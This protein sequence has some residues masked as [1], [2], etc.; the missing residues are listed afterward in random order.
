MKNW[1]INISSNTSLA[2]LGVVTFTFLG[3]TSCK[4]NDEQ[5]DRSKLHFIEF[6]RGIFG[7]TKQVK[8]STIN[9]CLE[10]ASPS[11]E[12]EWTQK[13][14]KA[15]LTWIEPIR[16]L[17]KSTLTEKVEVVPNSSNCDATVKIFPSVHAVTYTGSKPT[18]HMAASGYFSNYNV[19]LHE[20]GHVFGLADTYQNG[21][22]GNCQPGQPQAIMCNTAFKDMQADDIAG[23]S[24]VYKRA[25]PND[26]GG[27]D[28]GPV[29]PKTLKG[30]MRLAVSEKGDRDTF[31][32]LFSFESGADMTGNLAIEFCEGSKISCA[33]NA[34][35]W[36]LTTQRDDSDTVRVYASNANIKMTEGK[37]IT[38]RVK[39]SSGTL[40]RSFKINQIKS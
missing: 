36:I 9:V 20:F 22:S 7:L 29:N 38:V 23:V 18:V 25:F 28:P 5:A 40:T 12:E 30:K 14:Q 16:K 17:S 11:T 2:M 15:T 37:T 6:G 32:V 35:S 34:G 8:R 39:H 3:L 27:E 31:A 21:Q 24:S 10:G 19:L 33:K 1:R 13:I 4:P 26:E